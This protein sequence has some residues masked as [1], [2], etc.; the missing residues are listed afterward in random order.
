MIYAIC[1]RLI[2]Y[3]V[4]CQ[5]VNGKNVTAKNYHATS[6]QLKKP[7][8]LYQ[9]FLCQALVHA[10]ILCGILAGRDLG[11]LLLNLALT[12]GE[13]LSLNAPMVISE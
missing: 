5:N 7:G 12:I 10:D 9:G 3:A 1:Y 6:S 8:I 13:L 11:Y 4:I 2:R